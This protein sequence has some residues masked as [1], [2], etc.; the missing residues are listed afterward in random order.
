[1][2]IYE[3][4]LKLELD[5]TRLVADGRLLIP[6]VRTFKDMLPVLMEEPDKDAEAYYMYREVYKVGNL[7]YDITLIPQ[8]KLKSEFAKTYGHCHP[9]AE[10][11]LTYPEVYQVLDGEA[12]FILQKEL[13]DGS[14]SVS[15]VEAKK[16]EVLLIPPNFCH[17]TINS[18]KEPL[19]LA[20]VVSGAFTSD[21]SAYKKNHG[22]AYYYTGEKIFK[23]NPSYMIT[24]N[25]R[26]KAAEINLRYG[27]QCR[28]LLSEFYTSPDKFV[29]LNKPSLL[30]LEHGDL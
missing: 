21:Y 24:K 22:A 19:L 28:D 6:A 7:R 23:Q 25:E 9:Q 20:N 2:I 4:P 26:V 1:M 18:G 14:Y 27:F 16:G 3:K 8:W 12:I 11:G 29:F 5:N 15:A 13:R 17:A 10:K 30:K